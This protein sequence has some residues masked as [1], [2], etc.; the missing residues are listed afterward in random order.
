M[1]FSDT[2]KLGVLVLVVVGLFALVLSGRV[3]FGD[4]TPFL[5]LIVGYLIGNGA[6]A[7]RSK[8]PTSVLMSSVKEDE[9]VTIHGPYPAERTDGDEGISASNP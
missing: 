7:V 5:T 3:E 9:V 4:I 6:A 8:A 1:M 2:G